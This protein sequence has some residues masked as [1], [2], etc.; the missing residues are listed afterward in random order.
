MM[1]STP[2]AA[3]MPLLYNRVVPLSSSVHPNHGM[4]PRTAFPEAVGVNAVPLTVD[5]FQ[6]AQRFYPIVFSMGESPAPLAL[7]GLNDGV[8]L[9]VDAD[10]NWR[11]ETYIPAFFRRYPFILAQITDNAG[12]MS[13]CFDETSP[14]VAEN[15]GE[16]LFDGAEPTES[17][18]S[19]LAFCEQF[20]QSAARTRAFVDELMKLEL[21]V[22]GEVS[23][24][25][26]GVE[27]PSVYRGFRMIAEDKVQALR[28][29]QARKMVNN[30]MLGL[31]YAHLF[32]MAHV[33]ELFQRQLN[34]AKA[35]EA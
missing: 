27:Q 2:P 24:Q 11:Q 28:G 17:T 14:L 8:N 15:Q 29:D 30:G 10:G 19:A 32:S 34:A 21:L 23:I 25:Q 13:L 3:Q 4:I 6:V 9:F 35:A 18:R 16:R 7:M 33:S 5:E 20:E 31:I 26:V 12:E 1:A 22:D